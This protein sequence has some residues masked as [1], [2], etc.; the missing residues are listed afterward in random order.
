MYSWIPINL[1]LTGLKNYENYPFLN[2]AGNNPLSL[3]RP[4]KWVS[5]KNKNK[6]NYA[7]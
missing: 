4:I 3:A 5:Y 7:F 2:S 1:N 6:D